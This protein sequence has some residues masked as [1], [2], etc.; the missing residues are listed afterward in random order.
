MGA[1]FNLGIDYLLRTANILDYNAAYTIMGWFKYPASPAGPNG[2]ASLT[3]TAGTLNDFV[4]HDVN[5]LKLNIDGTPTSG[6][7]LSSDIWY[8]FALVRSSTTLITFYLDGVS[9]ITDTQ[10]ISGRAANTRET[11]GGALALYD[12]NGDL[13]Y[14]KAWS[15]NLSVAEIQQEMN[16]IRPV[17][18]DNLH[19]W[20]P[21]FAGERTK[22][23]SGNGYD[24][25]ENGTIVN[26]AAP[27]V[28]YGAEINIIP[29]AAAAVGATIPVFMN[30]YRNQGIS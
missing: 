2:I 5:V 11:V 18:T 29:F 21:I 4:Y 12:L 24:W 6:T 26:A 23:Y 28:S 17:K 1:N 7:T 27:P 8:H 16:V 30:H 3:N 14:V 9:D 19:L 20:T 13:A 15:T 22:D 25:T 10:N